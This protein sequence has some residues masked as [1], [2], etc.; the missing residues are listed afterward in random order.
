M[1]LGLLLLAVLLPTAVLLYVI[2]E[3]GNAQREAAR[4]KLGEA[5]QG[6]LRLAKDRIDAF[7]E[8]RVRDLDARGESDSPAIFFEHCVRDGL[9]DSVICLHPDGSPAYPS[10][11]E[12][13]RADPKL[14]DPHWVEARTLEDNGDAAAAAAKYEALARSEPD[15]QSAARANQAYL[16]CLLKGAGKQAVIRAVAERSD[17]LAMGY[18]VG[19]DGRLI[20]ADEFRLVLELTPS[21]ERAEPAR[22]L[23]SL[24]Q[25]YAREMPSSQRLYLMDML[26]NLVQEPR[27]RTFPTYQAERGVERILSAGLAVPGEPKL[28][29]SGYADAWKLT[30]PNKR[31]IAFYQ[32]QT[33]VNMIRA[34]LGTEGASF[35]V[36][37][38]GQL[39]AGAKPAQSLGQIPPPNTV[40][41]FSSPKMIRASS[42]PQ[43]IELGPRMP[44]WQLLM[45]SPAAL[46]AP[47]HVASYA[48][49]GFLTILTVCILAALGG[50]ALRRQMRI[51][52]LKTDLVAAVSHELKTPLTSMKLL[53]ESLLAGEQF[54]PARTRQYLQLVARENSRLSRLIDNFLTFSRMERNRARF[55]FARVEPR[56]IVEAAME[57][58]GDRF[59]VECRIDSGLPPLYADADALVTVLLNLLD[60][61]YK[62]TGDNRRIELYAYSR[63]GRVYFEVKDNGIGIGEREQEKIFRRFYQ[64][65]R[66]LTRQ[67]GGVGLGL[68]IVEFIVKSH[69]GEIAVASRPGAGSTFTVSLP[70]SS[71]VAEAAA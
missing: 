47:P 57:S 68:S 12:P 66:R 25:N 32:T 56:T 19:L 34:L 42:S 21:G 16:R 6:E 71:S 22:R 40:R 52:N 29:L 4:Q 65:D 28:E 24:V 62:Y 61:A 69:R 36:A 10:L 58:I 27:F 59:P 9:A 35:T 31:T 8:Q 60:N 37:P 20:S 1:V 53:V 48:W 38:P 63:A 7:W 23:F 67:A 54:D 51:A 64:V 5:Y 3:A 26:R 39:V 49:I 44:G 30:S 45:V 18:G 55:D 17:A 46:A 43:T 2:N 50:Q 41:V 11:A 14:Q 15:P 33:L 70:P 13:P